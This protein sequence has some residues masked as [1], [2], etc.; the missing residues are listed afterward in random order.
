MPCVVTLGCAL[1]RQVLIRS[2]GQQ[3]KKKNEAAKK[4]AATYNINSAFRASVF[5]AKLKRRVGSS[6]NSGAESTMSEP[7]IKGVRSP[8]GNGRSPPA[9]A[10]ELCSPGRLLGMEEEDEGS[11]SSSSSSSLDFPDPP[12]LRASEKSPR[13]RPARGL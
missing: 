11:S 7:A 1:W 10:L 4:E 6:P 2:L 13:A 8:S 5:H 12:G 9:T 3:R